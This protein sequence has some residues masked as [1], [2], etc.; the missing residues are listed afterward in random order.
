MMERQPT[1]SR[2]RNSSVSPNHIKVRGTIGRELITRKQYEDIFRCRSSRVIGRGACARAELDQRATL[3]YKASR[4]ILATRCP[5]HIA[6][7]SLN[8]RAALDEH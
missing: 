5:F 6:R 7:R 8:A 1:L 4:L 3:T 2:W